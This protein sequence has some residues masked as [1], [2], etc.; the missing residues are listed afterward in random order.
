M[1]SEQGPAFVQQH[2]TIRVYVMQPDATGIDCDSAIEIRQ[3]PHAIVRHGKACSTD[4][5]DRHDADLRVVPLPSVNLD[6][7]LS[8]V[9]MWAYLSCA[10]RYFHNRGRD[11]QHGPDAGGVQGL[12]KL[13]AAHG[14][15]PGIEITGKLWITGAAF[16]VAA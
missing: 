5:T 8:F 2:L 13:A 16:C 14:N 12:Q 15:S 3:R 6:S 4:S 7:R 1:G 9:R 11:W 10:W